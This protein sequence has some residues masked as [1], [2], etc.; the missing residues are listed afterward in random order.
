MRDTLPKLLPL[1]Q[2]RDALRREKK[3]RRNGAM[4]A[5]ALLVRVVEAEMRC[6]KRKIFSYGFL[7]T[8]HLPSFLNTFSCVCD[9]KCDF[10]FYYGNQFYET[11]PIHKY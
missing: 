5:R 1:E 9:N 3:E 8:L 10:I 11:H 4:A 2:R 6:A 7:F